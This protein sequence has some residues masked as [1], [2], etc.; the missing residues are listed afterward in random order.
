MTTRGTLGWVVGLAAFAGAAFLVER[1][2]RRDAEVV[3]VDEPEPGPTLRPPPAAQDPVVP[4]SP[5]PDAA[6]PEVEAVA[7]PDEVLPAIRV[8]DRPRAARFRPEVFREGMEIS[9]DTLLKGLVDPREVW[10]RWDAA[11]TRERF[12]AARFMVPGMN[13]LENGDAIVLLEPLVPML[14]HAGF[15]AR[16]DGSVLRIGEP[17]AYPPEPPT[18]PD[19]IPQDGSPSGGR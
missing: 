9:G 18:S 13:V 6:T 15:G 12:R 17:T 19:G 10:V 2:L 11:T 5:S 16:L 4:A 14:R 1:S 7:R 3:P 8:G